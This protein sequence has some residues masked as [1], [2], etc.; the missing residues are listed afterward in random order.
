M[1][2]NNNSSTST[3]ALRR[4]LANALLLA[5]AASPLV[6]LYYLLTDPV[7]AVVNVVCAYLWLVMVIVPCLLLGAL[8]FGMVGLVFSLLKSIYELFKSLL[9]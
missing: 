8:L 5:L 7:N 6:F 3:R 4:V 2:N 9:S 1:N